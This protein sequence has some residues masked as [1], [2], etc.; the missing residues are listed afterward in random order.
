MYA[1]LQQIKEK[2]AVAYRAKNNLIF[3]SDN[4]VKSAWAGT[5][6]KIVYRAIVL[7]LLSLDTHF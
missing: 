2:Y 6:A 3:N 5:E 4:A 1:K 7:L